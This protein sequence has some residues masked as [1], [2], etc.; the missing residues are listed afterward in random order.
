MSELAGYSLRC[1]LAGR[2]WMAP[3][4]QGIPKNPTAVRERPCPRVSRVC[5]LE[6]DDEATVPVI[7]LVVAPS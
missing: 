5:F 1:Q 6:I 4:C 2:A 3:I 7:V